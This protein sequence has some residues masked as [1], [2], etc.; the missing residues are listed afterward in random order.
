MST[1]E[2]PVIE[3]TIFEALE[4]E[5][6]KQD[7]YFNELEDIVQDRLTQRDVPFAP[8]F[9]E[10]LHAIATLIHDSEA[11]IEKYE[12]QIETLATKARVA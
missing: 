12:K 1:I 4:F 6:L 10:R 11:K 2:A 5:K 9:C 7:T 8:A 3:I